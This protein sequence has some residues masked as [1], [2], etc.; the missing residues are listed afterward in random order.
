VLGGQ[1]AAEAIAQ[2]G[3]PYRYGGRDPGGFDCSGLVYFVHAARGIATPRT[4]LEQY[5]SARPVP[6]AEL[7]AGD[8]LFFHIGGT[9]VSHVA[10]YT[11]DGRFVHAPQTGKPV[12]SRQLSE[13]YFRTRLLG[14]GR[15]Y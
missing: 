1:I 5:R 4:T 3:R 12:E 7:V 11:G 15:L 9:G 2:L 13:A 8:L 14:V 10:I 6:A